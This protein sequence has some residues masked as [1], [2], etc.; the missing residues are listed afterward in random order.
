MINILEELLSRRVGQQNNHTD[1]MNF[2]LTHS[3]INH[4]PWIIF[5]LEYAQAVIDSITRIMSN[6]PE[7][8]IG[9]DLALCFKKIFNDNRTQQRIDYIAPYKKI[10]DEFLDFMGIFPIYKTLMRMISNNTGGKTI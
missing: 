2:Q 1:F 3:G 4:L 6:E 7:L 10:N 8:L 9:S 5:F